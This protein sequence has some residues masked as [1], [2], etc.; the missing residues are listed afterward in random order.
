M[1]HLPRRERKWHEEEHYHIKDFTKHERFTTH[2]KNRKEVVRKNWPKPDLSGLASKPAGK[3]SQKRRPFLNISKINNPQAFHRLNRSLHK[4]T[5]AAV[6][7][8]RVNEYFDMRNKFFALDHTAEVLENYRRIEENNLFDKVLHD[9]RM[10]QAYLKT[11]AR[12]TQH[13]IS[14]F[15]THFRD[16]QYLSTSESAPNTSISATNFMQDAAITTHLRKL[17]AF[18][19][20]AVLALSQDQ[21]APELAQLEAEFDSLVSEGQEI[22]PKQAPTLPQANTN[23]EHH[24]YLQN[25]STF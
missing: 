9:K 17:S 22:D 14:D 1:S 18:K 10:R 21:H 23:S 12:Q 15:E 4:Q 25:K 20:Q 11:E 6:E 2:I 7:D 24:N 5:S 19:K 3:V 13:L 8:I 16:Y